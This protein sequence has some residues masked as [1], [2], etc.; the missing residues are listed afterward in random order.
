MKTTLKPIIFL[1]S[2]CFL[3]LNCKSV[4]RDL[5]CKDF[6]NGT[7]EFHDKVLDKKY[8]IIRTNQSQIEQ[9]YDLKTN[10]M[11]SESGRVMKISWI[12]DCEYTALLDTIKSTKYDD[13]DLQMILA[14]GLN[15]KIINVEKNCATI[16]TSIGTF[17][18]NLVV[19]KKPK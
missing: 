7:F 18:K 13:L 15:N 17:K 2:A 16:E 8:V 14:G 11:E 3:L 4:N 19:C 9:V 5:K 12:N 1:I 6:E 10:K